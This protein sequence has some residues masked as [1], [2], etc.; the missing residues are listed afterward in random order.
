MR[1][2]KKKKTTKLEKSEETTSSKR[3]TTKDEDPKDADIEKKLASEAICPKCGVAVDTNK[4]RLCGSTKSISPVSGNVI[5]MLNGR[6][7]AAFQDEKR[8]YVTMA[9]RYNIPTTEWP[10]RFLG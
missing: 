1:T 6:I 5:W 8:A 9:V 10:K 2:F 3:E 4:C 7:V